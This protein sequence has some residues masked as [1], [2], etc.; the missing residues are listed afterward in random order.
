MK[1]LCFIHSSERDH[2]GLPHISDGIVWRHMSAGS[3]CDSHLAIAAN[4]VVSTDNLPA[5][6]FRRAG[7]GRPIHEARH[8]SCAPYSCKAD[9]ARFERLS[10]C[11]RAI[12]LRDHQRVLQSLTA[13]IVRPRVWSRRRVALACSHCGGREIQPLMCLG[14]YHP[15]GLTIGA[16]PAFHPEIPPRFCP[17]SNAY[18]SQ[19]ELM[20]RLDRG[21][22]RHL[23]SKC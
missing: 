3:W 5:S 20:V 21:R 19:W 15:T 7:S 1:N 23:I 12:R 17:E 10:L 8:G 22:S 11:R 18:R 4:L 2:H 16:A 6:C 9:R 13:S 14:R